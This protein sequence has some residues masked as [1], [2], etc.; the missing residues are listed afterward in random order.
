MNFAATSGKIAQS[1][2]S[3]WQV[4]VSALYQLPLDINVSG[5]LSAHEGSFVGESFSMQD[6]DLPNPR[7]Y[8]NSMPTYAYD[9]RNRLSD[10]WEVNFKVEKIIRLGDTGRMYFSAD[11]FNAFNSTPPLR[12]YDNAYGTFYFSGNPAATITSWAAPAATA[13]AYNELMNPLVV[14]VG[15]RFQL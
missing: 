2:F 10:I 11:I 6:P 3:R 5:T 4:K 7:S 13:G 15:M 12:Q 9:N 14:R 8:S 1:A